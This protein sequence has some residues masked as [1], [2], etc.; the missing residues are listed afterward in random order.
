MK[1]ST[2]NQLEG[3]QRLKRKILHFIRYKC[4]YCN[5]KINWVGYSGACWTE[6][7][8]CGW[9]SVEGTKSIKGDLF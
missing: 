7:S 6:C 4:K 8:N 9:D 5:S 3:N 2:P 1:D